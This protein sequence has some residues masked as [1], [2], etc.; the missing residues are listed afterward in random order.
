M[1]MARLHVICGNCGCNDAFEYSINPE[2]LDITEGDEPKFK[3][4]VT[5]SCNNCATLHTLSDTIEDS[6]DAGLKESERKCDH[7]GETCHFEDMGYP[8]L[9]DGKVIAL[10]RS[11]HESFVDKRIKEKNDVR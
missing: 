2:G 8:E 4:T 5:I 9:E 6:S 7:C 3:P 11:C 1:V 10:C